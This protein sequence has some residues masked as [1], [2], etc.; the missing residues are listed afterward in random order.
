MFKMYTVVWLKQSSI[1]DEVFFLFY[2]KE[3]PLRRLIG[4]SYATGI[5]A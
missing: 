2:K 5:D 3:L 1:Q 4:C